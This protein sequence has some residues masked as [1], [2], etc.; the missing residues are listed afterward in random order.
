[1]LSILSVADGLALRGT[2]AKLQG[3]GNVRGAVL[4][5]LVCLLVSTGKLRHGGIV[6]MTVKSVALSMIVCSKSKGSGGSDAIVTKRF[7]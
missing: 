5:V 2:T 3:S 4:R 1:M 7:L 6:S